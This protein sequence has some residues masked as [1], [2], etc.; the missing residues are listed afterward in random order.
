MN[1]EVVDMALRD[2]HTEYTALLAAFQSIQ[3]G[4]IDV[5]GHPDVSYAPSVLDDSGNFYVFVSELSKHTENLLKQGRASV[6]LIED[7]G[8]AAQIFARKRVTFECEA[9]SVAR[10]HADWTDIIERFGEKF[11]R[12]VD[13]LKKMDDFHL[14][15]L[16]PKAGRLVVGFGKAYDVSGE[17]MEQLAHVGGFTEQ[18]HRPVAHKDS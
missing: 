4:S 17:R 12:V 5:E 16:H 14:I 18:G 8:V 2:A 11:G 7:E 15:R 6:M 1:T 13:H 10:E 9:Q 3:I